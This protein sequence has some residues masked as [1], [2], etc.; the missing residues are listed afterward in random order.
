MG[1]FPDSF[2]YCEE[3][4]RR[5]RDE[6]NVKINEEG[7][8]D[9]TQLLILNREL[10]NLYKFRKESFWNGCKGVVHDRCLLDGLVFTEYFYEK[11]LVSE[12]VYTI[13]QHYWDTYYKMYDI[14][15]YPNPHE[16][17]L[18]DD[19]ER[20]MD[21]SFR[22][23]IIRKYEKHYLLQEQWKDRIHIISGT[24]EERLE[25]IKIILNEHNVR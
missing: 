12:K 8:C 10:E 16:L 24:V 7:G 1:K 6:C 4:T 13:A 3:V 18:I 19:G 15:L 17:T 23:E 14:I 5:I 20:S 25:Q 9:T 21:P 11:K 22:N 2:W